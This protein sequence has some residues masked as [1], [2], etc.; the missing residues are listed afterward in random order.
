M[1]DISAD[2]TC[3]MGHPWS[4]LIGACMAPGC[5]A[6]P[7]SDHIQIFLSRSL[8]EIIVVDHTTGFLGTICEWPED[9]PGSGKGHVF[10]CKHCKLG[11]N[12]H[13]A[14]SGYR[15]AIICINGW[16]AAHDLPPILPSNEHR[17]CKVQLPRGA[18]KP[19]SD[20]SNANALSAVDWGLLAELCSAAAEP[21]EH[22]SE[23]LLDTAGHRGCKVYKSLAEKCLAQFRAAR[24]EKT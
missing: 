7:T 22:G 1:S 24:G 12:D 16:R 13:G 19:A 20:T 21:D 14:G 18:S 4:P 6:G 23:L 17:I 15:E 9:G 11:H 5:G 10:A 8:G 3:T 2:K